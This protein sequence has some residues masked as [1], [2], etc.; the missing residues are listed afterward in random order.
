LAASILSGDAQNILWIVSFVFVLS[1]F[2]C[3]L[4]GALIN[5][6][7]CLQE[8]GSRVLVI[9]SRDDAHFGI[10]ISH[11]SDIVGPKGMVYVVEPSESN[12]DCL[13]YMADKRSN[14]VPIAHSYS[15]WHYRML[16]NFVD[17]LFAAPILDL[18][19]SYVPLLFSL[20]LFN[21]LNG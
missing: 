12:R 16:I 11:I 17:V 18:R 9:Y 13:L 14:I 15:A 21:Q 3:F 2:L 7:P 1:F 20:L 5:Y 6:H 8:P 4:V 19:L 10:T